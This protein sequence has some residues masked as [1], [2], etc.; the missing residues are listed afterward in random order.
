MVSTEGSRNAELLS[1]VNIDLIFIWYSKIAEL[2]ST[3]DTKF[4]IYSNQQ[5]RNV[6]SKGENSRNVT[7]PKKQNCYLLKIAELVSFIFLLLTE[8]W[9]ITI[10]PKIDISIFSNH[11]RGCDLIRTQIFWGILTW[12]PSIWQKSYLFKLSV[13]ILSYQELNTKCL[14]DTQ[15]GFPLDIT[16]QVIN[17]DMVI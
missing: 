17:Y 8:D 7:L 12:C 9:K 5:S 1:I 10:Y 3:E 11:Y 13:L 16:L 2:L 14:V 4:E 15:R 6:N